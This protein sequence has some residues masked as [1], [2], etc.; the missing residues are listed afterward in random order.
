[1]RSRRS[2]RTRP[3]RTG[4]A[5]ATASSAST[6][7]RSSRAPTRGGRPGSSSTSGLTASEVLTRHRVGVTFLRRARPGL[8]VDGSRQLSG[9]LDVKHEYP[10]RGGN[11]RRANEKRSFRIL[12]GARRCC[13]R[14]PASAIAGSS[15]PEEAVVTPDCRTA[16]AR[17]RVDTSAGLPR[18]S[19]RTSCRWSRVFLQFWNASKAIPG[20]PKGFKRTKLRIRRRRRQRTRP[21]EGRDRRPVR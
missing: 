21:T 11:R 5:F 14:S 10:H 20:I 2:S 1:M 17:A 13:A 12:G 8:V 4:F 19:V 9:L 16:G 15:S 7:A 18:R 6:I 3:S